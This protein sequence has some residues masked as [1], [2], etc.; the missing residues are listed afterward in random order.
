MKRHRGGDDARAEPRRVWGGSERVSD[1]RLRLDQLVQVQLGQAGGGGLEAEH[2]AQLAGHQPRVRR[3]GAGLGRSALGDDLGEKAARPRHAEQRGHAHRARGLAED[4]HVGRVTAEGGDVVPDPFQ[5]RDLVEQAAVGWRVRQ[6]REPVDAE[7]VVDG[8]QHDAIPR[9]GMAVVHRHG[10]VAIAEGAAMDPDHDRGS[11]GQVARPDVQGEPV[12]ARNARL[13]QDLVERR[14]VSRL[15]RR[16]AERDALA[17]AVPRLGRL[18][19][20]EP[21][22]AGRAGRVRDAQEPGHAVDQLA[23]NGA[24]PGDCNGH[25]GTVPY[26]RQPGPELDAAVPQPAAVP[27]HEVPGSKVAPVT[28]QNAA[29]ANAAAGAETDDND[30]RV[31]ARLRA[32]RAGQPGG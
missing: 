8:D 26:V 27:R 11:P 5:R 25:A 20:P 29:G 16:R 15:R 6:Q 21:E 18:R 7:P 24:V 13:G 31:T 19:S 23:A 9:E 17:D 22:R 30:W 12:V 1:R 10:G 32:G 3:I 28:E 4:R 14:G 2:R